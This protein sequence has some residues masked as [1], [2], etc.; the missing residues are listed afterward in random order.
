[1]DLRITKATVLTIA[2]IAI[3]LALRIASAQ[4][5]AARGQGFAGQWRG[6]IDRAVDE[7]LLTVTLQP[8]Q[9]GQWTGSVDIPEQDVLNEPIRD[10]VIKDN[11]ISFSI[12]SRLG[13]QIFRGTLDSTKQQIRG[14][15]ERGTFALQFR[16]VRGTEPPP[17]IA[18]SVPSLGP[19]N[20]DG[21]PSDRASIAFT[22]HPAIEYATRITTDPVA[23]LNLKLKDGTATLDFDR[24]NGY[25]LSVLNALDIAVDT[26]MVLFSKTSV[27][28]RLI[29]PTN[30]RALYFHDNVAVG[31]IRNAPILELVTHDPKQGAV[32]YTLDQRQSEQP[33]FVRRDSCL[34]CHLSRNSMDVPGMLIRS[35]VT[36][37]NGRTYDDLG[38]RHVDDRTPFSE[39][40]GGW[41]V[42]GT[43][44]APFSSA[45]HMGNA[46]LT[47][48]SRIDALI[49]PA[50]L[51]VL[52]L[53]ER[54]DPAYPTPYSDL[55]A[56]LVFEHQAHMTNLLT[57]LGWDARAAR[58]QAKDNDADRRL[59][60]R[61]LANNAREAVDY[62]LFVDAVP[63]PGR[64]QPSTTFASRFAAQGPRDKQGRTLR[65]LE[66]SKR[67]MRYPCS[68][69]IYSPA[70]EALPADAKDALYRRMWEILSGEDTDKKYNRLSRADKRTIIE[71]LRD[72]KNDLPDY[73]K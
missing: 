50:N 58:Y 31:F 45:R 17:A 26:Q 66:L 9:G 64:I 21:P 20:V 8:I 46:M 14:R 62:L 5:E 51:S 30:P 34:S 71:I 29:D 56:L 70:F 72:T 73:F 3:A 33:R 42:T 65:Q 6:A 49:V 37:Q 36:G 40:W 44:D 28:A 19:R 47:D 7:L 59:R 27:Q 23:Q 63:L 69:M 35:V 12:A 38:S 55:A 18:A 43:I 24:A 67:L 25:L 48:R 1:M 15:V 2:G 54:L 60:S 61:L 68:Y 52:S 4:I 13:V 41:F 16:L 39:R 32:F 11:A 57:R 22:D 10:V 53:R